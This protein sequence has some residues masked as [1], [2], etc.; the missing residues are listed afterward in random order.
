M[1]NVIVQNLITNEK[2]FL[3]C[4]DWVKKIAVYKRRLAV[5][6]SICTCKY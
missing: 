5:S 6:V 2:V 3:K 1:T 4:R